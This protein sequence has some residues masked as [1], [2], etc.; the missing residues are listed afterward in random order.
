MN[1]E[2]KKIEVGA[3]EMLRSLKEDDL[4][5]SEKKEWYGYIRGTRDCLHTLGVLRQTKV[6]EI[7]LEALEY[8]INHD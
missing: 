1:E 8:V 2:I 5:E 3:I 4:E 7:L 6:Q